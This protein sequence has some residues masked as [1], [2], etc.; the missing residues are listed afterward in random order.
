MLRK[1]NKGSVA[2]EIRLRWA[3]VRRN[4]T[5]GVLEYC[6][7][8]RSDAVALPLIRQPRRPEMSIVI[9]SDAG[10]RPTKRSDVHKLIFKPAENPGV[11]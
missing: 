1:Y 9:P 11:R 7:I 4:Q 8:F 2:V 5:Y 3:M 10:V 6:A